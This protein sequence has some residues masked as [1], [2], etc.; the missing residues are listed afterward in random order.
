MRTSTYYGNSWLGMFIK[1]NDKITIVPID[2]MDKLTEKISECL[3]TE[4]VRSS[5]GDSNLLGIYAVMNSNGIIL[6]NIANENEVALIRKAGLNVYVSKERHNAHGNNL[7]VN[8]LGGLINPEVS[9]EEMTKIQ[10]VLGVELV[11]Q[12]IANH[13]TVGSA[14]LANNSGFLVHHKTTPNEVKEIESI[15]KV[16]G[17][18]GT[19]NTGTGFV[20]YGAIVNNKGYIAG[21]ATTA[22]ELGRIEE[23]FGLIK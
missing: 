14:C 1:T 13:S 8:D 23:A 5:F 18:R 6:P 15:L 19:V 4:I 21:E 12:M 17:T 9:R 7:S 16:P 3:G 11:P 20:S 10:D 2:A 22:F